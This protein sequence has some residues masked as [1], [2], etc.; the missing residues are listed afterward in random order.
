MKGMRFFWA[1]LVSLAPVAGLMATGALG[2]TAAQRPASLG[3][4]A[5]Q[6]RQI[7]TKLA[8]AVLK[9]DTET[10]LAYDRPDLRGED[11][12]RLQ[13]KKSDLSCFLF[14]RTCHAN[15]RPSIHDILSGSKRLEIE[16]Q[17]LRAKGSPPHGWLLFFDATKISRSRLQSASYLCQHSTEIA[18]WLFKLEDNGWV[19]ANPI[20]DSETDTFCS[21]R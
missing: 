21:P 10:L 4:S 20:F 12:L 9:H 17:V 7:G 15:G 14:D 13:D 3:E 2:S 6:L 11:R 8:M 5:K 18:S 1:G 19:S 16:V